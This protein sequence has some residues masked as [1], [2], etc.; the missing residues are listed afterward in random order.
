MSDDENHQEFLSKL[1]T[2]LIDICGDDLAES[3]I[4]AGHAG[5]ALNLDMQLLINDGLELMDDSQ[6]DQILD[7][8]SD[9]RQQ[10]RLRKMEE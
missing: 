10:V 5:G 1:T 7:L 3:L 9:I 8:L 2:G 6:R 4:K